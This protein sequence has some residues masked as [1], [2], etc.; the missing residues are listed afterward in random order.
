M[1]ADLNKNIYVARHCGIL[2]KYFTQI[3]LG[4]S[5]IN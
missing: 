2:L 5:D 3:V 1:N 4:P